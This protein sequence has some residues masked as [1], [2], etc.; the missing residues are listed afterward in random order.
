MI[1]EHD[2]CRRG[3]HRVPREPECAVAA[4]GVAVEAQV[5]DLVVA[6]LIETRR[7]PPRRQPRE[8]PAV[9]R[10]PDGLR[11]EQ[12]DELEAHAEQTPRRDEQRL[13]PRRGHEPAA[14]AIDAQREQLAVPLLLVDEQLD[15]RA[16]VCVEPGQRVDLGREPAAFRFAELEDRERSRERRGPGRRQIAPRGPEIGQRTHAVALEV[17]TPA[18]EDHAPSTHVAARVFPRPRVTVR[19]CDASPCSSFA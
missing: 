6:D 19:A 17:L 2:R 13:G 14:E 9:E 4:E 7:E 18:G 8:Q 3:D 10:E 5:M 12:D 1:D 11:G 16:V 15:R